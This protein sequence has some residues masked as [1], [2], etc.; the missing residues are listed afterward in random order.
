MDM[1]LT[2]Q[3]R[4]NQIKNEKK[5]TRQVYKKIVFFL[6]GPMML[7][8]AGFS[9]EFDIRPG[10][11]F[12]QVVIQDD[13]ESGVS[14]RD[15][16]SEI[17]PM[18]NVDLAT[19]RINAQAEYSF[20][21]RAYYRNTDHLQASQQYRLAS[22]L[23]FIKNRGVV[24]IASSSGQRLT[25]PLDALSIDS[26]GYFS[27]NRS[28]YQT[29]IA[30]I[31]WNQPLSSLAVGSLNA[32]LS[33]T[34]S[35][36]DSINDTQNQF[37]RAVLSNGKRFQRSFWSFEAIQTR[38]SYSS[39]DSPYTHSELANVGFRITK[40]VSIG[41]TVGYESN[42]Q[43]AFFQ[44][45]V[46]NGYVA[47]GNFNWVLNRRLMLNALYGRR[48]FGETYNFSANWQ[49]SARTELNGSYGKE[50]FGQT[51]NFL[52][53]HQFRKASWKLSYSENLTS[54]SY[55]EIEQELELLLD[56]DGVPIISSTTGQ[57]IIM[58]NN[59]FF[60]RDGVFV[61]RMFVFGGDITGRR[62][63]LSLNVN[64]ERRVFQEQDIEDQSY[65]G[66]LSWTL[67]VGNRGSFNT[68]A[69]MQ[70]G[71]YGGTARID[72]IYQGQVSYSHKLL[73]AMSA[74]MEYNYLVRNSNETEADQRQHLVRAQLSANW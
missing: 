57:P 71:G 23:E 61:R 13:V 40:H 19:R 72:D 22:S 49:P 4:T 33:Q 37:V 28:D 14:S 36:S 70:R 52:F 68:L 10:V 7:N 12:S 25:N 46:T 17:I 18:I 26:G 69:N 67:Q 55:A 27:G 35:E 41:A 11:S 3:T 16:I 21:Q 73:K 62:N 60:I 74:R 48:S 63:R 42:P 64:F 9:A 54:R 5:N 1:V 51:Y 39:K 15:F 53:S 59:L 2:V 50:V 38:Q 47:E 44:G 32:N 29:Y 30:G 65:G 45:N 31:N 20:E 43:G 6:V 34:V 56:E 66:N 58:V 24:N 8:K